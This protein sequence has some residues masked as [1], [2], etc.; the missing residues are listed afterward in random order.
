MISMKNVWSFFSELLNK[1]LGK[2]R[3]KPILS[4]AKKSWNGEIELWNVL[5]IYGLLVPVVLGLFIV[6]P[7]SGVGGRLGMSLS[8]L[9]LLPYAIWVLKSIWECS[10]QL[11]EDTYHGVDKIYVT[12]VAKA[13]A[14]MGG[15]QY[16][17]A[18]F[19]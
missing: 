5:W 11:Q 19:G 13:Y 2:E 15:L 18:L 1:F 10:T 4:F 3:A 14:V 16:F 7:L 17:L 8:L 12:Y 6:A 9:V